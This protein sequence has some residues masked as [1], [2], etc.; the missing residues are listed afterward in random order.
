MKI[1]QFKDYKSEQDFEFIKAYA[2][3]TRLMGVIGLRMHFKECTL[4]FHLD[5]EEY[6]LDRFEAYLGTDELDE[7]TNSF[8][9]GLGGELI[10]ISYQAACYYIHEAIDV[11]SCYNY[12]VPYDYFEYEYMIDVFD[13]PVGYE[14]IC[15]KIRSTEELIQY[16]F[17]R[18]AGRDFKIRDAL[19]SN[20]KM[21]FEFSDDP[22]VLLKNEIEKDDDGYIVKSYIDYEKGYKMFVTRVSVSDKI[23][24][25]EIKDQML[26]TSREAAFQLNKKEYLL[27]LYNKFPKSFNDQLELNFKTI[28]KNQYDHGA[29]YTLFNENN[30]HVNNGVYY[31]NGDINVIIYVT[32]YHIVVSSFDEDKL[33]EMKEKLVTSF[34]VDHIAD[35]E[36]ENPIIYSFVTSGM[37]NFFEFL[38]E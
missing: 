5:F 36:A 2:T 3:N 14:P 27:V 13:E 20:Q 1:I 29:L 8:I 24:V 6:G 7:I 9:G 30:D 22:T 11:G 19:F 15:T 33:N 4:F 25:C 32:D 31:L 10:E 37:N 34:E 16:F 17:M 12:E 35:L 38:G 23:E 26:I 28:L 21:T 18:T